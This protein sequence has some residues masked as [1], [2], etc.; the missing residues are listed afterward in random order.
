MGTHRVKFIKNNNHWFADFTETELTPQINGVNQQHLRHLVGGWDAWLKIVS[1]GMESFYMT[2][3]DSPILNGTEVK[4]LD[5]SNYKGITMDNAA[6]Y[7]LETYKGVNY[8]IEFWG[9]MN[10]FNF[11]FSD[12]PSSWYFIKH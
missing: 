5:K 1:E 3:S 12:I 7:L 11:V 9:C 2:I 10:G 4:I 6:C 8:N